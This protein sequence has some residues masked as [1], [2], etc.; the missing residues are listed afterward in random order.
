MRMT[1]QNIS[2]AVGA[3]FFLALPVIAIMAGEPYLVTLFSRILIYAL[4]A[5]SLD[6]MLG[7]GGLVSLG[8]AAF[9]GIGAYVVCILSMHAVDGT[10]LLTWPVV[11]NGSERALVAWPAAVVLAAVAAAAIGSL[12][13]RTSGMHFIMITLA[14]AQMLYYFFVSLEAYGG[15]D[16]IS[17]FMRNTVP[18]V[19]LAADHQFYY[20]CLAALGLF[21]CFAC[22]LV[23]SRFGMVIRGCRENERRMKSMGFATFR[24]R[25]VC[26]II[27]GAGA[28]LAGALIANQ[29]EYVSPGLMHWTRSGEILVMVLLGGMGTLF[30]PVVGAAVLL[31]VEEFLSIYTEHW[32]VYLGPFLVLVVL[33]AKRGIYGV[34]IG[35]NG[36]HG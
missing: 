28:G 36:N 8:H 11:I 33:F 32:M 4:A 21:L 3:L 5:V 25:L 23:D 22:R 16:G 35:G 7:F 2:I 17:L 15:D 27:A 14:F 10:A 31:L 6:L 12:S 18:G 26:F 34:I 20:V 30:G 13:L 24:Y 29:T 19:D 1:R 9:F